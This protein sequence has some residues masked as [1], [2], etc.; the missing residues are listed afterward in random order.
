MVS[1]GVSREI[2]VGN[3]DDLSRQRSHSV[4]LLR[5]STQRIPQTDIV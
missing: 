2:L 3:G 1:R 4:S 5:A